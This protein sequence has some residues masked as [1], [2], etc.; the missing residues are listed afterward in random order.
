VGWH[1]PILADQ[2]VGRVESA[3]ADAL[4]AGLPPNPTLG[5]SRDRKGVAPMLDRRDLADFPNLRCFRPART[6]P[7][8]RRECVWKWPTLGN[9][10]R[11]GELAAEIR[12]R[13]HEALF[14]QETV[15]A[16]EAWVQ[17]VLP[18]RTHRRQAGP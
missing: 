13:F 9:N 5:Y 11:R 14:K 18:R 3:K 10:L 17:R 1:V 6:A 2:E 7:G 12:H 4:A 15:L 8:S 16:T